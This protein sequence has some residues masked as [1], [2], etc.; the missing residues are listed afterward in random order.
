V[1]ILDCPRRPGFSS[2]STRRS[3]SFAVISLPASSMAERISLN[4]H[5]AGTQALLGSGVMSAPI[6]VHRAVMFCLS[7]RL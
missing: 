5:T 6:T 4:R 1:V 3:A 2:T 7:M